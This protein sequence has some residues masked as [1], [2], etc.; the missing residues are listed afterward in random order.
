M[1]SIEDKLTESR[2]PPTR[3]SPSRELPEDDPVLQ[4]EAED[5]AACPPSAAIHAEPLIPVEAPQAP[6]RL[7]SNHKFITI[8][9]SH[10]HPIMCVINLNFSLVPSRYK[11]DMDGCDFNFRSQKLLADHQRFKHDGICPHCLQTLR[12]STL[13]W[14]HDCLNSKRRRVTGSLFQSSYV[15]TLLI[16]L[17]ECLC[18]IF[19]SKSRVQPLLK[20][21]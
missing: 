19:R 5:L 13:K 14:N 10:Q 3:R 16:K 2:L 9:S 7:T 21:V 4:Q 8:Q 11:C 17:K 18:L 6:I 12:I 20:K 1:A 15:L